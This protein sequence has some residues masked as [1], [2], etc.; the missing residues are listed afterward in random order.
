MKRTRSCCLPALIVA[1]AV[2]ITPAVGAGSGGEKTQQH[3]FTPGSTLDIDLKGGGSVSVTGW[4]RDEARVTYSDTK[5][6]LADHGVEIK[7]VNGGLRITSKMIHGHNV[8][9]N[10]DF[11][12]SVP[13]KMN[14]E[15]KSM[16]GG[17]ELEN[18]EGDF[19]GKTMGGELRLV[20]VDGEVHIR[21]MG[22][23]IHVS[24]CRLDG[25]LSTGG[26]PVLLENVVG[27]LEAT[28]GG[29]GVRYKNVRDRDGRLRAPGGLSS[30]DIDED[31]VVIS[32]AGGSLDISE[33]PKGARLRTGG[34]DVEV[35]DADRFV[36]VWTGGGDIDIEIRNGWVDAWTGAG[37]VEIEVKRSLGDVEKGIEVFTG[38]GDVTVVLPDGLSLDMDLQIG[39]TRNSSQNFKIRSDFALDIRETDEWDYVHGSP[40]K[41]IQGTA[42]V[43]GG[44]HRIKIRTTNGDIRIKKAH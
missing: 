42:R 26:G 19:Q 17:L 29:G 10:L 33:A 38:T 30:D 9:H 16:G 37:D 5:M 25:K 28:S 4:D 27:D 31:T 35:L 14:L 1:A 40:Q 36:E 43:G 21:S 15:F 32:T 23:E 44:E 39:Y 7:E 18:L 8:S 20:R 12:I 41:Y 3:R 22:G 24:E 6:D 2:A 13:R 11:E 34:G